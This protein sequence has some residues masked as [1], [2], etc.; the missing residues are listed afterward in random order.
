MDFVA[1]YKFVIVQTSGRSNKRAEFLSKF[2]HHDSE[3]EGEEVELALPVTGEQK[4]LENVS[5]AVVT[6]LLGGALGKID[7]EL[8]LSVRRGAKNFIVWGGGPFR[9]ILLGPKVVVS[10][11]KR[12]KILEQFHDPIEQWD[13]ATIREFISDRF[14]SPSP[15]TDGTE[16]VRGLIGCKI[17]TP[18]PPYRTALKFNMT[19]L[20]L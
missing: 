1:E 4:E 12:C 3:D 16:F 9:R 11:D 14:G 6:L 2:S 5:E 8:Y 10:K 18:N 15:S 17:S 20:M 13:V 7:R 19:R